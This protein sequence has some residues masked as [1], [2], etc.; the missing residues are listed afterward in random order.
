[1]KV[2]RLIKA[3]PIADASC[4]EDWLLDIANARG[5]KSIT[6]HPS[7]ITEPVVAPP[8]S[9]FSNAEL[10][11]ALCHPQNKDRPQWFRAA[12]ELIT[13]GQVDPRDLQ[14]IAKKERLIDLFVA[15][16]EPALRAFP[17]DS[18]WEQIQGFADCRT[19]PLKD[20]LVHWSRLAKKRSSHAARK[21]DA[22]IVPR[23]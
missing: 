19:R 9:L 15:L 8:V 16:A 11:A 4:P 1:M 21:S 17:R 10:T 5:C 3:Y 20:S 13:S 22:G 14:V 2:G 23:R 18:N 12:A 7:K 6:R